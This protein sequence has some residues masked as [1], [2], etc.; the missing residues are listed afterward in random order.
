[1]KNF[2]KILKSLFSFK[3]VILTI[4]VVMI[5]YIILSSGFYFITIDDGE[6]E[7]AELGN[8]S[9]Y[10]DHVSISGE[11]GLSVSK[12][13]LKKTALKGLKYSDEEIA[14]MSDEEVISKLQINRKLKKKPK[15]KSLDEV[16]QAELLWCMNDVYS[17]Y[18]DKPEELEKLLNAEIITQYPDLG[19]AEGKLNGIIK[20]ER[21]KEDGSSKFLTY[22]DT[23]TFSKYVDDG[24]S[25]A[26]D[27]F[28]LDDTGN[29]VIA[30]INTTTETLDLNDSEANISEYS[31]N[32]SEDNKNSDGNYKKVTK[33]VSKQTIYYKNY[34]QNYTLPFNYLWSLLVI[35]EDKSFVMELADLAENSE[36]TISIYDN[37]TTNT[38]TDVYTYKKETRTDTY[39]R[40]TPSTTYR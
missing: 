5:V 32:L 24:D 12:D 23:N 18:L 15:V 36:I 20:F 3:L 21:H 40:V 22:V 35:G 9:N 27:H 28:T 39:A 14:N 25:K 11:T 13:D 29:V 6:W 37:I 38:N 8:P 7:D 30:S 33:T 31:S 2:K 17:Q 4:V 16:T 1:M 34:V 10:T 19:D 26:L